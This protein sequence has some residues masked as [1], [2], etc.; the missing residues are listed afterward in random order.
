ML[1]PI[2]LEIIV[3]DIQVDRRREA[4]MERLAKSGKSGFRLQERLGH[5]LTALDYPEKEQPRPAAA[6]KG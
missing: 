2:S 4:K 5:L 3:E 6:T 1:S